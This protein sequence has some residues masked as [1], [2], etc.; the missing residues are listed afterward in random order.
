MRTS[1]VISV[2]LGAG[3]LGHPH[4]KLNNPLGHMHHHK[5][6]GGP[7]EVKT[8]VGNGRVVIDDIFV[9]TV[10]GSGVPAPS[11]AAIAAPVNEKVAVAAPVTTTPAAA[12]VQVHQEWAKPQQKQEEQPQQNYSPPGHQALAPVS[13]TPVAAPAPVQTQAAPA[14][15]PASSGGSNDGSPMS[16][17][18]S[19]LQTANYFRKLQGYKDLVYDDTLQGN[20]AKTGVDNGGNK[21]THELN[22]G[23]FAQCIAEGDDKTGSGDLSPFDMIYLGWL[24]EIPD[25][26]LGDMCT[27]MK[28]T[29]HMKV[30]TT[31]PGHANILRTA[32]Y[33]KMGC[34]YQPATEQQQ[35][36]G[37]W[38]CDF[39]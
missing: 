25:S 18:K 33:T 6:Q 12:P 3:A 4:F 30:D 11:P 8:Y 10:Y 15:S 31:D 24:C 36:A 21:M 5:R 23:S 13:T 2:L 38:T 16:G 34:S 9:K 26:S 35:Y 20:S 19:L 27:T 29:V 17:G 39:A 14:S 1:I 37:Q 22:A 28:N 7:P 32:S